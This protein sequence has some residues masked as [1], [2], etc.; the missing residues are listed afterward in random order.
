MMFD[1]EYLSQDMTSRHLKIKAELYL[2]TPS[3]DINFEVFP[4]AMHTKY[5]TDNSF[6]MKFKTFLTTYEII[7]R[8]EKSL[9]SNVH[10]NAYVESPFSQKRYSK[11]IQRYCPK[12][13]ETCHCTF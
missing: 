11:D 3:Q 5:F 8:I 7:S 6:F 2:Y 9:F 10:A 13:F 12:I 1:L 4:Y